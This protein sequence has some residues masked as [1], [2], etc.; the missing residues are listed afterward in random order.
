MAP[1]TERAPLTHGTGFA[2]RQLQRLSQTAL[3]DAKAVSHRKRVSS[4]SQDSFIGVKAQFDDDE[5]KAIAGEMDNKDQEEEEKNADDNI[6]FVMDPIF[7]SKFAPD[8]MR[9]LGLVAHNHMKPS[10]KDFVMNHLNLLKKF[11]LTGTGSTMLMLREV[12]GAEHMDKY[13]GPVCKSGPLGGDAELVAQMCA[14]TMGA[15]FFF[16]DPMD[17]HPHSADIECLNRQTNVH[18]I[19][20]STNPSS[21]HAMTFALRLALKTGETSI[22]PSLFFNCE[23]PSVAEYKTRQKAVLVAANTPHI[24]TGS[25]RYPV[26]NPRTRTYRY[27]K[28]VLLSGGL[29][30]HTLLVE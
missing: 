14:N 1:I 28:R 6:P 8:E 25:V 29:I 2:P 22:I 15:I 27:G 11:K 3:S 17:S 9:C 30:E 13:G 26:T 19:I 20:V 4:G 21:A 16:Q 24:R 12:L 5:L 10:M 23:S 7:D 18:N